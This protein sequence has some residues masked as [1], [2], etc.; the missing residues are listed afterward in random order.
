MSSFASEAVQDACERAWCRADLRSLIG[1][2]S[3]SP[4][5]RAWL[6]LVAIVAGVDLRQSWP[7]ATPDLRKRLVRFWLTTHRNDPRIIG[8][9][10]DLKSALLRGD[11]VDVWPEFAAETAKEVRAWVRYVVNRELTGHG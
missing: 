3:H 10:P 5:A 8:R 2:Q 6:W 7:R 4:E 11:E 9:E 1:V